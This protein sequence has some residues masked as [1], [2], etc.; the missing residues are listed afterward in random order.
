MGDVIR[1]NNKDYDYAV[2]AVCGASVWHICI[3]DDPDDPE[4]SYIVVGQECAICKCYTEISHC[5]T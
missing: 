4:N 3:M 5:P 2:C 1:F